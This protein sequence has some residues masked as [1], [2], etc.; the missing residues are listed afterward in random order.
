MRPLK[1]N[2][3][4]L[5]F[6]ALLSLSGCIIAPLRVAAPLDVTVVDAEDHTPIVNAVVVY[7]VCDIHDFGCD[8]GRLVSGTSSE[9]GHV[10]IDGQRKWG[11]WVIVPGGVPIP[12]HFI[13]IWAPGYSAYVFAQ[14]GGSVD[15][16]KQRVSRSDI[17]AALR[18]IPK[19][20]SSSDALLN[21]EQEL[22]GGSIRLL[23][24]RQ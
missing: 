4:V 3:I 17:R 6:A 23:K 14:Y 21:A 11:L 1:L 8:H 19:D 12:N 20:T 13:A 10:K 9:K 22:N 18:S 7:L 5:S 2:G 15:S 24:S 16:I